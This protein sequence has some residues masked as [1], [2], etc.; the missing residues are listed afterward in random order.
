MEEGTGSRVGVRGRPTPWDPSSLRNARD[1]A[2]QFCC[3]CRRSESPGL[4]QTSP[5]IPTPTYTCF[6]N[7]Q[8]F[9]LEAARWLARE[10]GNPL[11]LPTT[12][13]AGQP[14]LAAATPAWAPDPPALAESRRNWLAWKSTM[15]LTASARLHHQE[16]LKPQ[17]RPTTR[18][19]ERKTEVQA[20]GKRPMEVCRAQTPGP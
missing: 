19:T 13:R 11:E 14:F 10:H 5:L 12:A 6:M 1:P 20:G 3:I 15:V 9:G 4:V 16:V 2:V 18:F 17:K 8:S 7:L